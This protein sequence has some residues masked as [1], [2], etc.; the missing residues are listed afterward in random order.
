MV[1]HPLTKGQILVSSWGYSMTIVDYFKVDRVTPKGVW[2]VQI[3]TKYVTG[4]GYNGDSMPC[5][6]STRGAPFFTRA[7]KDGVTRGAN[8]SSRA[9]PWNGQ[10]VYY[11]RVD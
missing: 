3:G 9:Y 5:E 11:N 10:P 2:L 1:H 4:G 8:S 6:Q 7:S